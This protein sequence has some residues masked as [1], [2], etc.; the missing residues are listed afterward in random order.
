MTPKEYRTRIETLGYNMN[1][2]AKMCRVNRSTITRHYQHEEA[3]DF[4][5][6]P[7]PFWVILGLLEQSEL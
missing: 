5:K 6:I 1:Q 4:D 7:G 3:G 2:W